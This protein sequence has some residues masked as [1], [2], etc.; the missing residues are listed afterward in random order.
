MKFDICRVDGY[1]VVKL[2]DEKGIPKT[3]YR[4]LEMRDA[5]KWVADNRNKI[6]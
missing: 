3:V 2:N 1:Y 6:Q 4:C 5:L